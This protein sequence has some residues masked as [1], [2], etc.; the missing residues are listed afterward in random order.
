[1][2]VY[3][4]CRWFRKLF[5]VQSKRDCPLSPPVCDLWEAEAYIKST[6]ILIYNLE[7]EILEKIWEPF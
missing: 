7:K 2:H 3:T 6:A 4:E 1:M 5:G